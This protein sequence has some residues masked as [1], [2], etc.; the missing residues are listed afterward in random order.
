MC[1]LSSG[2]DRLA[3]AKKIDIES[4]ELPDEISVLF[5][6]DDM[7]LRKLFSRAVKKVEPAWKIQEAASGET[8]LDLV[9]G[10]HFDLIF[11]DQ[12][13]SSTQKGLLGT[14]T[15]RALRAK[16]ANG[17]ICGLSANDL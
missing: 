7:M 2:E 6:D 9:D 10:E 14:E 13:M 17:I 12:Y 15:V 8:A 1:V 11:M 3:S 4:L 5:V 16:G